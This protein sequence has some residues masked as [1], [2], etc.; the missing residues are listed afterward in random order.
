MIPNIWKLSQ[1]PDHFSFDEILWSIEKR[2][3]YIHKDSGA[4]GQ[5]FETQ[6]DEFVNAPIGDYFYLTHGNK[7]IYLLGQII[8]PPNIFSE[9]KGGYIDRPFR[10]I[11]RSIKNDQYEGQIKMVDSERE[12]VICSRSGARIPP[13]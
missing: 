7:G 6:A 13:F 3:I 2:L 1:G 11:L 12:F 4:K 9:Y 5:K 10:L 8:G